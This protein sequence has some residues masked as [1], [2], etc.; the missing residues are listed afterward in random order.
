M[1]SFLNAVAFMLGASLVWV[2]LTAL[3][4]LAAFCVGWLLIILYFWLGIFVIINSLFNLIESSFSFGQS[5][6]RVLGQIFGQIPD[7]ISRMWNWG[8]IVPD[9]LWDFAR[10]DHPWIALIITLIFLGIWG[11]ILDRR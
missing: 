10:Y 8:K 2:P 3:F 4:I 6:S 5:F 9:W 7:T 1:L 11:K